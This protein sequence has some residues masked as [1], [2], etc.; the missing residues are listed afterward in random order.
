MINIKQFSIG[1]TAAIITSMGLIA[2]LTQGVDAKV[3]IIT[4]LLIIAVAD[5]LSD[6]FSIHIYKES[7]GASRQEVLISTF[8]NFAVRFLIVLTFA[9]MV[10]LFTPN[11]ALIVSSIWG[12]GLLALLSYLIAREQKLDPLRHTLWHL[13]IAVLVIAGSRMLGNVILQFVS[14]S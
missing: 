8:G 12:L 11:V 13:A 5:N 7:E 14:R 10:M 3:G 4:G 6:S 9:I 2:G 1:A